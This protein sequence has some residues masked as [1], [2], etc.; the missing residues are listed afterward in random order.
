[1]DAHLPPH[2]P[3]AHRRNHAAK[4]LLDLV[5]LPVATPA[6]LAMAFRTS[7]CSAFVKFDDNVLAPVSS[8]DRRL[9]ALEEGFQFQGHHDAAEGVQALRCPMLLDHDL[10]GF[11]VGHVI[12]KTREARLL[13]AEGIRLLELA[14]HRPP[15]LRKARIPRKRRLL[16]FLVSNCSWKDGQL[17]AESDNHLMRLQIRR[18]RQQLRP[19]KGRAESAKSENWLLRLDL[20]QQPSG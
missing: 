15:S 2:E 17:T 20:N 11:G 4:K 14:R 19:P 9:H 7:R 13:L 10:E 6:T 12:L 18:W 8:R 16:E 1:M 5:T 3:L